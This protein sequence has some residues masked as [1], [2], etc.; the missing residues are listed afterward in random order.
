VTRD[1][2]LIRIGHGADVHAL[3]EGRRLVLG[4]VEVP[5]VRGLAGHS[6]AD[7]VTHAICNAALGAAALGD[8]GRHFPNTDPQWK[9]VSSLDLLAR[10]RILLKNEGWHVAQVDATV[11]AQAPR[12]AAYLP[13]MASQLAATLGLETG[14]VNVKAVT[15]E[16]LGFVGREEGME[17]HAVVLLV[18]AE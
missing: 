4:G 10:V 3:A 8:L 2:L 5:S 9:D 13:A 18:P 11:M 14:R 17:A 1:V 12:L 6:D 16:R 15:T 7:V